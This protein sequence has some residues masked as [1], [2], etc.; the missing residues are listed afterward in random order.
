MAE[1]IHTFEDRCIISCGMLHPEI[2]YLMESGFLNPLRILFTPPGLHAL[3]DRLEEH[4]LNRLVQARESCP[5]HKIIVVYGKK[6]YISTDEP[7]KR[8]DSILQAAGQGI[9]RVQGDYGYDM[10]V[11]FEDRQRI[12]GGRQDKILWFT[13]G[14]LKHWKV[15]YQKYFGW[16]D[17]DAN[18]NFPG[19]YDKIIVLDA[20]GVA[21]EY[22]TQHAEEILELFDWTGLEVEFHP[23]TLDRFKGLLVD[24]LSP[25]AAKG[26]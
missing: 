11:G 25:V 4:L 3:P 15:I 26:V 23:I 16:D 22:M 1:M 12:S 18:A 2:T 13:P 17:A 6:C 21:E 20:L 10:L 5:D 8:V 14:W 24:S 9:V 7:L 19:F